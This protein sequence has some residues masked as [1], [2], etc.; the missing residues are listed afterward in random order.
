ML[1]WD[2]VGKNVL[3]LEPRVSGVCEKKKMKTQDRHEGI[4]ER[5]C[6]GVLENK[7]SKNLPGNVTEDWEVMKTK[8]LSS[9]ASI[10]LAC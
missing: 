7:S 3:C 4:L 5:P 9:L 8:V 6:G 10:S 2:E 1:D